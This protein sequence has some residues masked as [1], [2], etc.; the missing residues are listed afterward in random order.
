MQLPDIL[1]PV[2][3]LIKAARKGNKKAERALRNFSRSVITERDASWLT[4]IEQLISRRL[5]DAMANNPTDKER[6]LA[7]ISALAAAR[8]DEPAYREK[9]TE[10]V[11]TCG[12][13]N[14]CFVAAGIAHIMH[15]LHSE[16]TGLVAESIEEVVA[17]DSTNQ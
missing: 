17:V 13:Y 4:A 11:R 6:M 10:F 3:R 1:P 9:L 7:F 5:M 14:A 16:E 15:G 2:E 8:S 12:V